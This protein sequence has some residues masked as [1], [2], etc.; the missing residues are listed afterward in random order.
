MKNVNDFSSSLKNLPEAKLKSFGEMA[1]TQEIS[2]QPSIEFI[3]RISVAT[4]IHIFNEKEKSEQGKIQNI[5]FEEKCSSRDFYV[6]VKFSVQ[7]DK[8]FKK[9]LNGI[10]GVVTSGLR[11]H[12]LKLLTHVSITMINL[13]KF[14]VT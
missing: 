7:S 5:Q 8:M 10:E 1:L 4:L 13:E 11:I 12:P 3:I 2:T 6:E 14:K 9:N